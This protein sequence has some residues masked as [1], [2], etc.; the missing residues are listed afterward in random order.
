MIIR[1]LTNKSMDSKEAFYCARSIRRIQ[2]D[3]RHIQPTYGF[4]KV[5]SGPRTPIQGKRYHSVYQRQFYPKFRFGLITT[6]KTTAVTPSPAE[7]V[8]E[9]RLKWI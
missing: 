9:T 8:L 2:A 5:F 3:A 4:F 6:L 7:C 1:T